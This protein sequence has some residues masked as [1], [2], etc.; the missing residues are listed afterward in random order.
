[1]VNPGAAK[2]AMG[3]KRDREKRG[4]FISAKFILF[5]P[6]ASSTKC[7]SPMFA[8]VG[9]SGLAGVFFEDA[10]HVEKCS[11][12]VGFADFIEAF[13]GGKITAATSRRR[14]SLRYFPEVVP[15]IF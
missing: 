3:I 4:S 6:S 5:F 12:A 7:L 2:V 11:K 13:V 14:I 9:G 10:A 15:W 8:A 1:M